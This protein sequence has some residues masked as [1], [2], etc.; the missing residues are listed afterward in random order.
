MDFTT[1][2][3]SADALDEDSKQSLRKE[4]AFSGTI[5]DTPPE[6]QEGTETGN[7][8]IGDGDTNGSVL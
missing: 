1:R 8:T 7:W 2:T 6:T 5:W 4:R 3:E